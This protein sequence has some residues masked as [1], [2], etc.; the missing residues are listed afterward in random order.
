MHPPPPIHAV[1]PPLKAKVE[2]IELKL[3]ISPFLGGK[4]I[5]FGDYFLSKQK[6]VEFLLANNCLTLSFFSVDVYFSPLCLACEKLI[7]V[8]ESQYFASSVQAVDENAAI[9]VNSGVWLTADSLKADKNQFLHLDLARLM[10][11]SKVCDI[12]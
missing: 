7:Q 11:V 8:N 10:R 6:K 4:V 12:N 1:D 5:V 3:I 9:F 2:N